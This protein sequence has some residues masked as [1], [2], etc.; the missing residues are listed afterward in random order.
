M[1]VEKPFPNEATLAFLKAM[2]IKKLWLFRPVLSWKK[3]FYFVYLITTACQLKCFTNI[4]G[5][6]CH[7]PCPLYTYG[8]NCGQVGLFCYLLKQVLQISCI[9]LCTFQFVKKHKYFFW[10][11]VFSNWFCELERSFFE[12]WMILKFHVIVTKS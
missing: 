6:H 7:R 4:T 2:K 12:S 10:N 1:Y 11:F 9:L 5:F 8:R 3:A